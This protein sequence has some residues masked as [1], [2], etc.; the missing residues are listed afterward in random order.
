MGDLEDKFFATVF[1]GSGIIYIT[2]I[3]VWAATFGALLNTYSTALGILRNEDVLVYGF[4]FMDELIG[5]FT[6]RMAAVYM[7]SIGSLWT[8]TKVMPRWLT[9]ITFIVALGLLLFAGATR[10]VRFIFPGWVLVVSVYVLITNR[11]GGRQ[12]VAMAN[13]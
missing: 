1:L 9:I 13:K 8:R 7:M 4:H 11:T 6:L 5:S 12:G 2:L 3:F 10:E